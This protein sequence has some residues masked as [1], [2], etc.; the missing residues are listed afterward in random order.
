[1]AD[2]TNILHL[3]Y[4]V[5]PVLTQR[6]SPRAYLDQPVPAE[7]LN[8]IFAA[9]TSA[10][11]CIGEQ[12]WRY[13]AA[14]REGQPEAFARLLAT[15]KPFNQVWAKTA[16]VLVMGLAKRTFAKDGNANDWA[17]HDLGQATATLAIQATELG[18]QVHQMGGF[19]PDEVRA[20][21]NVPDDFDIVTA[22]TLGYPGPAEQLDEPLRS[23][24]LAPRS[25]MPVAEILFWGEWPTADT[26]DYTAAQK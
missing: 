11:S 4:E 14:S 2:P 21:F 1:M 19:S 3:D 9:G 13:L 7:V 8:R 23:R 20:A 24:E 15:L 6:R 10:A 12:P 17:R 25:R 22:F 26:E 16:P 18:L 5:L